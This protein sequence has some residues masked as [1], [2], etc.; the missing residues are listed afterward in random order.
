MLERVQQ[1][2]IRSMEARRQHLKAEEK[3]KTG[4][5]LWKRNL[6]RSGEKGGAI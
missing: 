2:R 5:N 4:E 1:D 3:T 6:E